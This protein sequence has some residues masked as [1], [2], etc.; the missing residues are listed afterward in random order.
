MS[1][2]K[3]VW[4]VGGV[5]LLLVVVAALIGFGAGHYTN[6]T[7]TVGTV[8][9]A[10]AGTTSVDPTVAAGA[11]V[12]VQFACA[13]CHGENGQ[14]GVS[15]D[16]PELKS[17]GQDADR[18]PAGAHHRPRARR[19]GEPD[20][21]V[22]AGLGRGDLQAPGRRAR[23]VHPLRPAERPGATPPPVPRDQGLEVAGAALYVRDGCINCHGPNGLGGVPNPQSP[24]K[25]IPPLAGA[26]FRNE[27]NTDKKITDV[28]RSGSVIGRAPIVSM[29]HWGGDPLG[30]GP[31]GAGR[32]H[33]DVQVALSSATHPAEDNEPMRVL[34]V[35]DE[36][37][38]AALLAR[39]LREEGH[40]ADVAG[41]ARTRSGW[42]GRVDYDAIVL[43]VMLPGHGRLR[44]PAARCGTPASGRPS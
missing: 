26:D 22:H 42:R 38:L 40:A 12:F 39:G 17:V 8:A 5:V 15:P 3:L 31:A 23:R 16:V 34:V 9:A 11:H 43:D 10:A 6:R 1:R 32:L 2:P 30:R 33:Q 35:E 14:G 36:A 24:D 21:A 20:Q 13:Q 7:K 28:I 44:R 18:R 27:F 4:V 25:T 29:P 19:V 37:K 41:A